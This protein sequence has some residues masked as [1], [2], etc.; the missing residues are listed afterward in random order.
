MKNEKHLLI[1]D[2]DIHTREALRRLLRKLPIDISF[3]SSAK[4]AIEFLEYWNIDI[5]ITDYEMHGMNGCEL[6]RY[7]SATHPEII[8]MMLTGKVDFKLG[9]EIVNSVNIKKF[10]L[11]PYEPELLRKEI[12]DCVNQLSDVKDDNN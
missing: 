11:K 2:D 7:V 6:L 5:L 12:L 8:L 3:A 1:V 4:E 9:L 10:F